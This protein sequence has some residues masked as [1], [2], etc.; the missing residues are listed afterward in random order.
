MF[1]GLGLGSRLSQLE[2]P[3]RL[4]WLPVAS[5]VLYAFVTPIGLAIG[6]GIRKTSVIAMMNRSFN[7][8]FPSTHLTFSCTDIDLTRPLPSWSPGPL[9]P[10]LQACCCIPDWLNYLLTTLSSI[11]RCSSSLQTEKSALL[12]AR[13]SVE[14]RKFLNTLFSDFLQHKISKYIYPSSLFGI[15]KICPALWNFINWSGF[16][17]NSFS[18]SF[19]FFFKK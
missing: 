1:E 8:C 17:S 19:F 15:L 4:H 3:T 12:L 9:M 14:L 11:E 5:G 2:L 10:S 6:L 18:S 16:V 13:C 7:W